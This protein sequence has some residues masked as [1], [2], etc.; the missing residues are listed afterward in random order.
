MRKLIHS[1]PN[2]TLLTLKI[3]ALQVW[4]GQENE[5]AAPRHRMLAVAKGND[6]VMTAER[7]A[8]ACGIL[9]STDKAELEAA[10]AQRH[11]RVKLGNV[12]A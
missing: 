6:E 4:F 5:L 3:V 9:A 2:D 11:A 8:K 7:D 12:E 10:L 1:D